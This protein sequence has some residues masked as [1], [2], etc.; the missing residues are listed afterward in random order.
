MATTFLQ[1][2]AKIHLVCSGLQL[3]LLLSCQ[4]A[5]AQ[6]FDSR[7][8][9][10]KTL[11]LSSDFKALCAVYT[12]GQAKITQINFISA[13]GKTHGQCPDLGTLRQQERNDSRGLAAIFI[14]VGEQKNFALTI[15]AHLREGGL[16]RRLNISLFPVQARGEIRH[17]EILTRKKFPFRCAPKH[18]E[19]RACF[20]FSYTASRFE[21]L[22]RFFSTFLSDAARNVD[23]QHDIQSVGGFENPRVHQ[24]QP[25]RRQRHSPNNNRTERNPGTESQKKFQSE[26]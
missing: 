19:P 8:R 7:R 12:P 9:V 2:L 6:K 22:A 10:T 11:D 16:Q 21:N 3:N 26:P 5:V 17:R 25:R 4:E 13:A 20:R 23:A 15:I 18:Q 14:A 24:R 1:A